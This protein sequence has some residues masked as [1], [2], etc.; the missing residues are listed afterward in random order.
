[1]GSVC[2]LVM[3][4]IVAWL[5]LIVVGHLTPIKHGLP[6]I[7]APLRLSSVDQRPL[8][9]RRRAACAETRLAVGPSGNP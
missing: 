4:R 9:E 6:H 5:P 1:M 7:N 8:E 3:L 2:T